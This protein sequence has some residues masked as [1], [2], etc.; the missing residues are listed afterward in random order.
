RA[1]TRDDSGGP[2]LAENGEA[3]REPIVQEDVRV[4]VRVAGDEVARQAAEHDVPSVGGDR[5]HVAVA[6]GRRRAAGP[7][8]DALRRTEQAVAEENVSAVRIAGDQVRAAAGESDVAAV[9]GDHAILSAAV[10]LLA[11]RGNTDALCPAHCP[12]E[13]ED[14]SGAVRIP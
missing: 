14:V 12:V 10:R 1:R 3:G 13:Q 6:G 11:G 5:G 7:D 9:V 8:A 2:R 4:A